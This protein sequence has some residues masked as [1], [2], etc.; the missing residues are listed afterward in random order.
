MDVSIVVSSLD[1]E[2]KKKIYDIVWEVGFENYIVIS[3]LIF[4][5]DELENSPL[6]SLPIVKNIMNEGV[7]I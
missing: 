3:P 5:T 7:K 6:R 2:V 4:I 1:K